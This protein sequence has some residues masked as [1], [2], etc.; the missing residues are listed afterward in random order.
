MADEKEKIDDG[1]HQ[2]YVTFRYRDPTLRDSF[3]KIR[4]KISTEAEKRMTHLF[5]ND[6]T[7]VW[8]A[9]DWEIEQPEKKWGLKELKWRKEK[10][11]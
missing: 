3:Y 10:E 8:N 2:F 4:A 1:L 6:W 9:E 11:E 7:R 5:G